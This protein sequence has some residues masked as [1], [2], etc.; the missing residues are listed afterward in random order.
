MASTTAR[1]LAGTT[2][3]LLKLA[4]TKSGCIIR[5][6][7]RGTM[8]ESTAAKNVALATLQRDEQATVVFDL[9]GCEYLDSTFLGCIAELFRSYGRTTP[10]RFQVAAGAE[11]H[12]ALLGACR[13][14][15]IIPAIDPAPDALGQWVA[16]PPCKSEPGELT[17]HVISCHKALAEIDSPMRDSF[18]KLAARLE[19]EL[20]GDAAPP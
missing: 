16:L 12:A 14:D 3:S 4:P 1:P 17:R 19:R 13:M 9:S 18:A 10:V 20:A 7:G 5:I 6:E 8:H 11:R 15:K 2:V